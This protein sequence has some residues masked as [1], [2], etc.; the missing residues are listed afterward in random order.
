[1]AAIVGGLFVIAAAVISRGGSSRRLNTK[2]SK[3]RA[4]LKRSC[5]HIEVAR[6]DDTVLVSSLCNSVGNNPWMTCG[7]CG[8]RF[9]QD[10]HRSM[11]EQW[12]ARSLEKPFCVQTQALQ[13][14]LA[15]SEQLDELDC[16]WGRKG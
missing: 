14:S 16:E 10:E 13:K 3:L 4:K 1:M 8:K 12:L 11:V 7:L 2:R 15:L 9:A 6:R 5:P